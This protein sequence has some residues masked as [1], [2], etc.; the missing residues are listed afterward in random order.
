MQVLRHT[1]F[2]RDIRANRLG[3]IGRVRTTTINRYSG[4]KFQVFGQAEDWWKSHQHCL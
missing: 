1:R 4:T 2:A 3:K